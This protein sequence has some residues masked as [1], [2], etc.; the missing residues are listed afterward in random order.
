MNAMRT[1]VLS[2]VAALS[3]GVAGTPAAADSVTVTATSTVQFDDLDLSNP[4]DLAKLERRIGQAVRALCGPRVYL[5]ALNSDAREQCRESARRSANE[6]FAR[7]LEE[8]QRR[9][10]AALSEVRSTD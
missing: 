1:T 10:L 9:V 2:I 4:A 3:L 7:V 5:S 6:E 8:D